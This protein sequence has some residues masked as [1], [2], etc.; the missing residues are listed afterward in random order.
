M[1]KGIKNE[2]ALALTLVSLTCYA[3]AAREETFHSFLQSQRSYEA[4]EQNFQIGNFMP[5]GIDA[6]KDSVARLLCEK[7]TICLLCFHC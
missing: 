6:I 7:T 2:F 1:R 4:A 5:V 3:A